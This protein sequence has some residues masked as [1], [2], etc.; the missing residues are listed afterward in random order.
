MWEGTNI[1][2]LSHIGTISLYFGATLGGLY[3]EF[4]Q[5][6][7]RFTHNLLVCGILS[8][9]LQATLL[10]HLGVNPWATDLSTW[11]LQVHPRTL[12]VLAQVLLLKQ[13][14]QEKV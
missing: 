9:P 1:Q 6:L 3:S 4:S 13:D 14:P 5:A 2:F 12:A 10:S 11:P 8:E 7:T